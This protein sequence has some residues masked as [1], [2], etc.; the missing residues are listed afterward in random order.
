M[1]FAEVITQQQKMQDK[2]S[3]NTVHGLL[4]RGNWKGL[5]TM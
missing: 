4:S 3:V 5:S 1:H 2:M